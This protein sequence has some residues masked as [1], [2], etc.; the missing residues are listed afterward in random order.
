MAGTS[1]CPDS[2][3][4]NSV[5]CSSTHSRMSST[6]AGSSAR[7]TTGSSKLYTVVSPSSPSAAWM[8]PSSAT[9]VG[10]ALASMSIYILMAGVLL[11]RPQGL[12]GGAT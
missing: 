8:D 5:C 3:K 6:I 1:S 12:F 10:S 11:L 9:S 2:N 4:K 7:V